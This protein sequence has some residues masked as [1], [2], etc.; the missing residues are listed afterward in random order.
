[1]EIAVILRNAALLFAA[2][3]L[4][5]GWGY[6]TDRSNQNILST[7]KNSVMHG[8][9]AY[10]KST[11]T[12]ELLRSTGE[13]ELRMYMDRDTVVMFN[14][15]IRCKDVTSDYVMSVSPKRT[16]VIIVPKLSKR[17]SCSNASL[18]DGNMLKV[19]RGTVDVIVSSGVIGKEKIEFQLFAENDVNANTTIVQTYNVVVIRKLRPVDTIFRVVVYCVQVFVLTGFGAELDIQ[20]VKQTL[21]KPVAPAIG[22]CCQYLVMPLVS[23]VKS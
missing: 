12:F 1:M 7:D 23:V 13:P 5:H 18:E 6:T 15:S 16:K 17:H 11:D 4:T 21:R 3:F 8:G 2:I 22:F 9:A 10:D 14:Y 19:I 20:V